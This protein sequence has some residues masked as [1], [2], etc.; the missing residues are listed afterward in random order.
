MYTTIDAQPFRG[1]QN[2]YYYLYKIVNLINS[3]Y[4]YGVHTSSQVH[5]SYNGSG[6]R[7][8]LAIKKYGVE[9]FEKIILKFFNNVTDMLSAE[10]ELVNDELV[11][12]ENCYNIAPGGGLLNSLGHT[13]VRDKDGNI[14]SVSVDDSRIGHSLFCINTGR[15]VYYD[16]VHD[17]FIKVSVD[18]P[19]IKSGELIG[20]AAGTC[21]MRDI[22][23]GKVLSVA[24]DDPRIKSGE[25]VSVVKNTATVKDK[26]GNKYRVPVDD[27]RIK[28]GELVSCTTNLTTVRDKDG[29]TMS[30]PVDDPRIKSGELVNINRS[31]I[32]INNGIK[33]K[34]VYREDLQKYLDDGWRKGMFQRKNRT[35]HKGNLR[36][37][38][39]ECDLQKYLDDGWQLGRG[40]TKI[41]PGRP[42]I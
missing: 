15:A 33:S 34:M 23:S 10:A 28:S 39:A 35:I 40:Q 13:V 30:V 32:Y 9:N 24:V 19:R 8:K 38:V 41:K 29:N 11:L 27:P 26:Y 6:T 36:I 16:K 18:D 1:E 31:R 5:D 17:K 2:R 42:K 21:K 25:L 22:K 4:Y 7:L 3:K 14:M 37:M 12:N 20:I